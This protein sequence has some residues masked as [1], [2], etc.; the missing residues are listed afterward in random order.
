MKRFVT[1]ASFE[2]RETAWKEAVT[3][4]QNHIKYGVFLQSKGGKLLEGL[5]NVKNLE[6]G[7]Q[8]QVL[9]EKALVNIEKGI[10]IERDARDKLRELYQ[11]QP[12]G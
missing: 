10:K 5:E 7:S 3:A 6:Q 11:E 9:F 8:W 12:K 2:E 4:T 1:L